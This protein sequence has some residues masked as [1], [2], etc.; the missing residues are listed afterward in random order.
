MESPDYD[1]AIKRILKREADELYSFLGVPHE[2]KRVE[3]EV[4]FHFPKRADF[5][6]I[7]NETGGWCYHVEFQ[8]SEDT[9]LAFRMLEYFV[10]IVR[11]EGYRTEGRNHLRW[12]TS[13]LL[14]DVKLL[15][16][17]VHLRRMPNREL[18]V[19]HESSANQR[20]IFNFTHR[21]IGD[22]SFARFRNSTCPDDVILSVLSDDVAHWGGD[23]L[24]K[25][26]VG[27]LR[28]LPNRLS[29]E[30]TKSYVADM[31]LLSTLNK[32]HFKI[33][34]GLL[35]L[36]Y[37]VKILDDAST[38]DDHTRI[39]LEVTESERLDIL[40]RVSA[41]FDQ[42]TNLGNEVHEVIASMDID[43]LKVVQDSMMGADL[44][45]LAEKIIWNRLGAKPGR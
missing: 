24:T 22:I 30:E 11:T 6:A 43:A 27:H 3:S 39:I 12:P 20:V 36:G 23:E 25:V 31:Y 29:I 1:T 28:E 21:F 42:S 14:R 18:A 40:N 26:L 44:A 37:S 41:K 2:S 5:L 45:A 34:K 35:K 13:K 32:T 16:Q 7:E 17:V 38:I 10:S 9:Q 15:Q 4:A 19:H 33:R 8:T